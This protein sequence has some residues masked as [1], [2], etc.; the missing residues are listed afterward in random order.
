MARHRLALV[1]PNFFYR[2]RG[3]LVLLDCGLFWITSYLCFG[4][5]C[6]RCRKENLGLHGNAT[7][8]FLSI[9]WARV[10]IAELMCGAMTL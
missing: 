2:C 7:I 3:R 4:Y 1:V 5:L 10:G 8:S 6:F 9:P